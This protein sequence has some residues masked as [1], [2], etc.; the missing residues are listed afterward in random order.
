MQNVN[1]FRAK[2][3]GP[4]YVK[5]QNSK[6]DSVSVKPNFICQVPGRKKHPMLAASSTWWT[7]LNMWTHVVLSVLLEVLIRT[8]LLWL[9]KGLAPSSGGMATQGWRKKARRR[10]SGAAS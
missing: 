3:M 5:G 2:I 4:F 7:K 6:C 8:W 1:I 9:W 10:A